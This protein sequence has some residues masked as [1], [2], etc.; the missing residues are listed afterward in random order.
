MMQDSWWEDIPSRTELKNAKLSALNSEGYALRNR[1][2][3]TH[4]LSTEA[5]AATYLVALYKSESQGN[6]KFPES[7]SFELEKRAG[8]KE[9]KIQ[10]AFNISSLTHEEMQLRA[11]RVRLNLATLR[12]LE[13]FAF[14]PRNI[15]EGDYD[16]YFIQEAQGKFLESL[17]DDEIAELAA[18]ADSQVVDWIPAHKEILI[19]LFERRGTGFED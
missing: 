11:K 13:S 2:I 5:F 18:I 1:E 9:G 19:E 10:T 14:S 3:E 17:S 6:Q 15:G 8:L 7:L 4:E 16:F 12:G